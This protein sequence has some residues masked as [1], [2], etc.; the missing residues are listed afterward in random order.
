M[1]LSFSILS[2][3]LIAAVSAT[4]VIELNAENFDGIVGKGKPGLVEL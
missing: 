3:A 1:R 2:A 4:N